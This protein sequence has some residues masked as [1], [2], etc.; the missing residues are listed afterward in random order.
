MGA[1]LES[2]KN[3]S[4][5]E[6]ATIVVSVLIALILVALLWLATIPKR[7]VANFCTFHKMHEYDFNKTDYEKLTNLYA[8]LEKVSPE[9]IRPEVKAIYDRYHEISSDSANTSTIGLSLIDEAS[10]VSKYTVQNCKK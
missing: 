4:K 9:E 8:N 2:M 10:A 1:I 7:S 3:M 6:K 5:R